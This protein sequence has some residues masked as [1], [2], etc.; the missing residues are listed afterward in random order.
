MQTTAVSQRLQVVVGLLADRDRRLL[1]QQRRPGTPCA[2]QWEFPGG[3]VERGEAVRAALSREL[4]EELGVQVK[5]AF[6][7]T[8]IQH[9]YDHARVALEVFVVDVYQGIAEGREG[10][11]IEWL[12]SEAIREMNVLEAVHMILDRPEIERLFQREKSDE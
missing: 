2:G 1:V 9:D 5:K 6:K 12:D 10:Q 3:K 8:T 7:L 11:S 4:E